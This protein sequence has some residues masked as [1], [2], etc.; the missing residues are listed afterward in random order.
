MLDESLIYQ[1][2][3][4]AHDL[5]EPKPNPGHEPVDLSLANIQIVVTR[6]NLRAMTAHSNRGP[7]ME[8]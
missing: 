6:V 8:K 5:L 7:S 1:S 3:P 2:R 4:R